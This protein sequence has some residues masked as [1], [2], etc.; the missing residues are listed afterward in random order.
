MTFVSQVSLDKLGKAVST[1]RA[2]L[3]LFGLLI[4]FEYPAL[5]ISSWQV[6]ACFNAVSAFH[7][8]ESM[9]L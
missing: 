7:N 5:N 3:Y 6:V 9:Q 2:I 4:H 1:K 8:K